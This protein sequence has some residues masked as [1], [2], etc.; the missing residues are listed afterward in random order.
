MEGQYQAVSSEPLAASLGLV[1]WS[2]D[3]Q[4][5][6]QNSTDA[7]GSV[8][9]A[10]VYLRAGQVV[11]RISELVAVAGVAVT[12]GRY[13]LFDSNFNLLAQT[14]DSPATFQAAGWA[15][16]ALTAPYIVPQSGFYYVAD[17]LAAATTMPSIGNLG[18]LAAT[19]ARSKLPN[20]QWRYFNMAGPLAAFPT[21]LAP[22]ISG[23]ARCFLIR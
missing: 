6:L 22:A 12:H 19:N 4:S 18:S 16:L 7:S 14:A 13:G 9:G 15:E 10:A 20:N 11:N 3:P 21:P 8:H 17:L 5:I 2:G 1:A 23:V